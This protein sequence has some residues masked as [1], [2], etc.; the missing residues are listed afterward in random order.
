VKIGLPLQLALFGPNSL[1]VIEPVGLPPVVSVAVSLIGCPRVAVGDDTWVV[2]AVPHDPLPCG[3]GA[4][5]P[6]TVIE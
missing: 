1:N 6:E 2:I 5:R 3:A 4:L